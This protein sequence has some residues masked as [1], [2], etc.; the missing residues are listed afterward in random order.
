M[1]NEQSVIPGIEIDEKAIEVCDFWTQHSAAILNQDNL[2]HLTVFSGE[3][4]V[5]GTLWVSQTPLEKNARNIMIY[6]HPSIVKY[7]SSWKKNSKFYLA[8]EEIFPLAH[9]LSRLDTLQISVGLYS[10]LKAL[11]FLHS[12]ASV[13]HNNI[14][15]TSIYLS[16]DGNW[17]LAGME[18]L[19]K[20][21]ELSCD[22]LMKTKSGRYNKSIDPNEEKIIDNKSKRKDAVDIYGFGVLVCEIFQSKSDADL[23]QLVPFLD[24]C[25]NEL[26]NAD[27]SKRPTFKTIL[28]HEFFNH[29]F[30]TIHSYLLELPLKSDNDKTHFFQNLSEKLL[31]F[32]EG[33]VAS[34]LS[35]LL[36][37][38]LVL[39]NKIAQNNLLPQLLT[40]RNGTEETSTSIFSESNFK[41]F[42]CPK[43]LEI[44]KVR[45]VEIRLLLLNYFPKFMY[46]F[47]KE[48]L[49]INILP[50]LLVGIKDTN[51]HLVSMTLKTL[52][53]LV[54]ILGSSVV[55][56]GKRAKLFNDGRPIHAVRKPST[57]TVRFAEFTETSQISL[58]SDQISINTST[59]DL[60]NVNELPE[61]QRPDGEEGETSTEDVDPSMEDDVDNW[62][63]WDINENPTTTVQEEITDNQQSDLLN[64][65][66]DANQQKSSAIIQDILQLDIKNQKVDDEGADFNF[67]QDMEPVIQAS[68]KF[69][70]DTNSK[71]SIEQE[72]SNKLVLNATDDDDNHTGW[73]EE[74]WE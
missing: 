44:F 63:D 13:S 62:E 1:G 16:I 65:E 60:H 68:N 56:G 38:R 51:D 45:D 15:L 17:K 69:I 8:V 53:N 4:F 47:T 14:C 2:N 66:T 46:A 49:Q 57:R 71:S 55:I 11:N 12:N 25:K 48:A 50:E 33:I 32:D 5:N 41:K 59:T 6:R 70:I 54:P 20:Y 27:V 35:G 36:L 72:L 40:P 21:S 28:E 39:L 19:C 9:E 52:A 64:S 26:K 22:Y 7:I 18:Y 42:V 37:S 10:I 24:Y 29:D 67:F 61:R 43:L 74:D 3:L 34:Q 31:K 23:P 58:E 30:I 73:E